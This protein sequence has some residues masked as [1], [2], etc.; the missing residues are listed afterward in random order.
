LPVTE[1][2][3]GS[4]LPGKRQFA[5]RVI[6]VGRLGCRRRADPLAG[7]RAVTARGADLVAVDADLAA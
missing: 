4:W 1:I 5:L 2:F 3:G 6:K 7:S